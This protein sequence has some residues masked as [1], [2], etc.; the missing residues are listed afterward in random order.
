MTGYVGGI[1]DA[2]KGPQP[3][4]QAVQLGIIKGSWFIFKKKSNYCTSDNCTLFQTTEKR[5][6]IWRL[7]Y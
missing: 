2:L 7:L 1:R 6:I 3:T 5:A 4:V